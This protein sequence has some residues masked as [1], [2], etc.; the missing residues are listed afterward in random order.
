MMFER[1]LFYIYSNGGLQKLHTCPDFVNFHSNF[2][3][4]DCSIAN[5]VTTFFG[6]SPSHGSSPESLLTSSKEVINYH[7]S[8]TL[9]APSQ[10]YRAESATECRRHTTRA[11]CYPP[12]NMIYPPTVRILMPRKQHLTSKTSWAR[13]AYLTQELPSRAPKN[14]AIKHL[15]KAI[16]TQW[17]PPYY[18]VLWRIFTDL[19]YNRYLSLRARHRQPRYPNQRLPFKR[20]HENGLQKYY[21]LTELL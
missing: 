16:S 12:Y 21:L 18:R 8:S 10:L 7:C 2:W 1:D 6:S 3:W 11:T 20:L 17:H 15:Q 4:F 19:H 13:D 14:P 5:I 9:P